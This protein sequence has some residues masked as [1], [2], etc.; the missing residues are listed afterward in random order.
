MGFDVA[1]EVLSSLC[2]TVKIG[3]SNIELCTWGW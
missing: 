1:A 3:M 2:Y